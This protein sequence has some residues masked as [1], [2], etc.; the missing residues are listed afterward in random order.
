MDLHIEY[1]QEKNLNWQEFIDTLIK[2]TLG[3][4]RPVDDLDRIKMMVENAN[5]I[6]TA[7]INGQLVGVARSVTDWVFCTYLSD[8]FVDESYQKLGI[9][10]ELIKQT[11]LAS[12][13]A[14]LILLS[15]PKAVAYYPRIGMTHHAHAYTLDAPE[16]L[17]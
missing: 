11:K 7:R 4:R 14:K 16:D 3:E 5:L 6:V 2:S 12:P 17:V 15:A 10:R 8:L 13:Q 9:G 1:A